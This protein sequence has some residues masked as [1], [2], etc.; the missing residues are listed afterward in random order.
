MPEENVT[1]TPREKSYVL[2]THDAEIARLGLQHSV[3]RTH[4]TASWRRAGF[5]RGQTLLDLGCGPGWA[6]FDLADVI[7]AEG[8]VHA[9]DV[10]RRFLD[11]LEAGAQGRDQH[12]V[13]THE[14][15]LATQPLPRV[16]LDGIWT[17]WVYAFVPGPRALLERA[18]ALL[19]PG[20]RMVIHEYYDYRGWRTSP[21]EPA[22]E[23]MV[24]E[25]M[26]SW[27]AVGGEPDIGMDLPR[28]LTDLGFDVDARLICEVARPG[29]P[30]WKWPEAFLRI[31]VQRLVD[32]GRVTPA[33][34]QAILD[35]YER[36]VA[37]PGA[38]LT[39]PGVMDI[40]ATKR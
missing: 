1:E 38:F 18:A 22:F 35:A 13:T 19:K 33:G 40:V 37:T 15:D 26:A 3:W 30:L 12:Q 4:A 5:A 29:D 21:A 7:G 11:A 28:W 14:I 39:T 2:G 6:T 24:G 31:G 25:I 20:G 27:R 9:V 34:Q 36:I 23:G 10:S 17:R 16:E 8:R 32:L